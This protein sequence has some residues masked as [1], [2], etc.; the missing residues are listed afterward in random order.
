MN[1]SNTYDELNKNPEKQLFVQF[2]LQ[3]FIADAT[4][5]NVAVITFESVLKQK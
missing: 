2:M 4:V 1:S 5:T 3:T